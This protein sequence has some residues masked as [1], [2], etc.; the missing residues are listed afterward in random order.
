MDNF[1]DK[2]I[3]MGK[4]I[5]KITLVMLFIGMILIKVNSQDINFT[6]F[7]YNPLFLNPANTGNFIGDWRLAG[8][9]RNQWS[10]AANP[11]RTASVSFDT[12]FNILKQKIGTGLYFINDESGAG[13]LNFNKVYASLGYEKEINKNFF[14]LG[15]QFGYVF[16]SVNS[17]DTWDKST[18]SV[19]ST[20]GE[21]DFKV[22]YPDFNIGICWRKN[23][24]IFEPEAGA[25]FFHINSPNNSFFEN[26]DKEKLKSIF[27]S[28]VKVKFND[29]IYLM[30]AIFYLNKDNTSLTILGTNIGY[31]F[32][33][34]VSRVKQ[35]FGGIYL[36]NGII[37]KS[38]SYSILVGTSI[39]R[40]DIAFS[41]DITISAFSRSAGNVGAY[42]I[43]LIY[44]N[45]STLINTY[46][47][48]CERF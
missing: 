35:V 38:D 26:S 37:N 21:S 5:R 25:S 19:K 23:L 24:G 42:E 15:L 17:W 8:N 40:L 4:S 28:K 1:F 13:G 31:N 11:F 9:Y 44:R 22:S 29:R 16:G 33:G 47:I 36:R 20:N 7:N 14:N 10:A 43:S 39:G 27:H 41:H 48:P 6:M 30:P 45:I 46:S 12:K 32:L 18:N 3:H 2:Y 34:S